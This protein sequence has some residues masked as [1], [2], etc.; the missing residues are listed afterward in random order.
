MEEKV[1]GKKM[2]IDLNPN[3]PGVN[4]APDGSL[5]TGKPAGK[6]DDAAANAFQNLLKEQKQES[7]SKPQSSADQS[8][9]FVSNPFAKPA[10]G[11]TT[12]GLTSAPTAPTT[13][14]AG[15]ATSAPLTGSPAAST[16]AP[17]APAAKDAGG[18]T[19]SA[20]TSGSATTSST[21]TGGTT[22][23]KP[24]Q[25]G[26]TAGLTSAP[27]T[28]DAS[29][30]TSA[31]L[32]GSPAA[33]KSAPTAPTTKD[34]SGATSAPLTGSPAAATS[35]P[36][37]PT[38]K[39]ASGATGAPLT[40][41][42]AASTSAPTTKDA[43]G[44]TGAPLTGS[45]AA[46]TSA[47]TAPTAKDA[48]GAIGAP[49]TGS[50]AASSSA[51][52]A[53][54]TTSGAPTAPTAKDAGKTGAI[55]EK[56]TD[57]TGEQLSQLAQGQ[58]VPQ[59]TN[60]AAPTA[61]T[62]A[63]NAPVI[64]GAKVQALVDAVVKELAV[65]DLSSIKL[66]GELSIPLDPSILPD[67]ALKVR[68]EGETMVVSIDSK[69]KDVNGFCRDNLDSLQNALASSAPE[70]AHVRVEIRADQQPVQANQTANQGNTSGQSNQ[71]S[72]SEGRQQAEDERRRQHQAFEPKA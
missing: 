64:D 46:S 25:G 38:T 62:E 36:T 72:Q 63:S 10:Q 65:R 4:Q 51:P 5:T 21:L 11:G 31:P 32:T 35:A 52:T 12:A 48:G 17:T 50:P 16:S 56:S 40:G 70:G 3:L 33:A 27:T 30:A 34:A 9:A 2:P 67:T 7:G 57:L 53:A 66:T 60:T 41:S 19:G 24:A 45:P 6:P 18:A 44:L 49:L 20:P 54:P 59:A 42:P 69:S 8:H 1:K 15:A 37:A 68:F 28:K 39:D 71:G 43:S 55:G 13:K 58:G 29:G 61:P 26:T 23:T 22:F 14:D 47:P